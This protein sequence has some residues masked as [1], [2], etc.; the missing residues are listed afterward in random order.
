MHLF[1]VENEA[2]AGANTQ[3]L[4]QHFGGQPPATYRLLLL[5][6][7]ACPPPHPPRDDRQTNDRAAA[8]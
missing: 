1:R 8:G 3:P 7:D 2:V 6:V 5:D 4:P